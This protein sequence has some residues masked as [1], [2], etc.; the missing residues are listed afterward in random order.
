MFT[1]KFSLSR[2]SF[3]KTSGF[4]LAG[5]ASLIRLRT[6]QPALSWLNYGGLTVGILVILN[7]LFSEILALRPPRFGE[8]R[9]SLACYPNRF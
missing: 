5:L 4:G 8:T 1:E 3:L 2:R 6:A 9:R 7:S